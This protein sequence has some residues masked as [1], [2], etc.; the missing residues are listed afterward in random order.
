MD[1]ESKPDW[2]TKKPGGWEAFKKA[3]E[4][5]AVDLCEIAEDE[6][7]SSE[8]GFEKIEK[9]HDK[10]KWSAFGKSKP[11]TKKAETKETHCIKDDEENPICGEQLLHQYFLNLL[12]AIFL[13]VT[14]IWICTWQSISTKIIDTAEFSLEKKQPRLNLTGSMGR[15]LDFSPKI[16]TDFIVLNK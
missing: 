2:N 3:G 10:M 8:E 16:V 11:R 6:G 15:I 5:N 13:T 7:Y 1:L 9:I 14:V 4:K 12:G